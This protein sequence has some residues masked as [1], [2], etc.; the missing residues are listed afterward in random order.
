MEVRSR[1]VMLYL[2]SHDME[3][4]GYQLCV[5]AMDEPWL[6]PLI[7]LSELLS[8]LEETNVSCFGKLLK[9]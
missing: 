9:P 6:Q 3:Y 2:N 7:S 5:L 1:G 8:H 4:S